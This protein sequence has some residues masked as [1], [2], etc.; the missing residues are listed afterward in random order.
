MRGDWLCVPFRCRYFTRK[1][2]AHQRDV[3]E[4]WL[5]K[6]HT[7]LLA[8]DLLAHFSWRTSLVLLRLLFVNNAVS[9]AEWLWMP[10]SHRSHLRPNNICSSCC[11]VIH[12]KREWAQ[13]APST[14]SPSSSSSFRCNLWTKSN[15]ISILF[16]PLQITKCNAFIVSGH[17]ATT[18]SQRCNWRIEFCNKCNDKH[19][20]EHSTDWHTNEGQRL[21]AAQL[22]RFH[23]KFSREI[24]QQQ[25]KWVSIAA[26]VRISM[27]IYS[28]IF[29]PFSDQT[30]RREIYF[31]IHDSTSVQWRQFQLPKIHLL[32]RKIWKDCQYHRLPQSRYVRFI[33]AL[34]SQ[35]QFTNLS[36][37]FS[38]ADAESN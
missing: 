17:T 31:S 24:Q 22:F 21:C 6:L 35:E 37:I 19:W 20:T 8:V 2:G 38:S 1:S 30:I 23:S 10:T 36:S 33:K 7:I 16:C 27:E 4:L 14:P 3:V 25:S 15:L 28:M 34:D 11:A 9:S 26:V 32:H 13:S 12:E 5:L 18:S 29:L